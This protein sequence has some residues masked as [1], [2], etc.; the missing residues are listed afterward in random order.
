[1]RLR[2]IHTLTTLMGVLLLAPAARAGDWILTPYAGIV[3]GG[4]LSAAESGA[5]ANER[6]GVYGAS[7]GYLGD[8]AVG[9]H[10]SAPW[11]A[12]PCPRRTHARRPPALDRHSPN[13]AYLEKELI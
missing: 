1:M 5:G 7:L 11:A 2:I 4:D 6:H 8:G 9:F 12:R 10:L 3:F 13:C